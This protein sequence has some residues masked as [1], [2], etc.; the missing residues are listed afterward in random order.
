MRYCEFKLRAQN[1]PDEARQIFQ[2]S[3]K[4]LPQRKCTITIFPPHCHLDVAL[5]APPDVETISKFAQLEFKYG[6]P[7]RGR[8][9]FEGLISTYPKVRPFIRSSVASILAYRYVEHAPAT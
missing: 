5:T 9:V 8:T 4:S 3:L 7:E 1:N 2:R 6:S